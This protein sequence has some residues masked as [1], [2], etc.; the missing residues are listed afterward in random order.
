MDGWMRTYRDS[1][2]HFFPPPAPSHAQV[3]MGLR[4]KGGLA[5]LPTEL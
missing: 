4:V 3:N 2:E 5:G 1:R